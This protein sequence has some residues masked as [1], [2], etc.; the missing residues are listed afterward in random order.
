MTTCHIPDR[1][2]RSVEGGWTFVEAIIVIAIVALLTGTVA[3]TAIRYVERARRASAEIQIE[4]I[5]LAL[6]GYFLDTGTYP[7]ES[8]GVS[9]LWSRP[10]L[11]PVPE[12][13]S[14]PYVDRPVG[15]DP[16]G[17]PF[18]YREPGRGGLPFELF[19]YGADGLPGGAGGDADVAALE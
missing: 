14:G 13:W 12:T 19:S 9:A 18:V 10:V 15:P 17:H 7:T 8:Q 11:S 6:H 5:G 2:A 16:W 4:S 3:F 1:S